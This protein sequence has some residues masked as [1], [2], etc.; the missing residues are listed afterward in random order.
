MTQKADNKKGE[1]GFDLR[2]HPHRCGA[3][4]IRL[5]SSGCVPALPVIENI[6][7]YQLQI[8]IGFFPS[9]LKK[10]GADLHGPF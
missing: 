6:I 2:D 4:L 9:F 3:L 8:T 10:V 5:H 1:P 7:G